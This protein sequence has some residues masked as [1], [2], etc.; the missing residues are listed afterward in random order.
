MK[1]RLLKFLSYHN[2]S[3]TKFA[4]EIGVQRSSISHILS[5]RNKPSYD[6]IYKTLK[7]YPSVSADWLITGNGSM[8]KNDEL[9]KQRKP[10]TLNQNDLFTDTGQ[11]APTHSNTNDTVNGLSDNSVPDTDEKSNSF[12]MNDTFTDNKTAASNSQIRKSDTDIEKV[13]I[14]YRDGTFTS[15][16]PAE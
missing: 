12:P 9:N 13:L 7:H 3:A 16:N 6:F 5:G 10:Y 11:V 4:D 1:E 2:I 15:Y 14:F 8:F